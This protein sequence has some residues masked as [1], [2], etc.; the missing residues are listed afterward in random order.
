MTQ[1]YRIRRH[2]NARRVT[3]KVHP[4]QSLEV[5]APPRLSRRWIERF[6]HER[7]DWIEAAQTRVSQQQKLRP[8]ELDDPFPGRIELPAIGSSLNVRYDEQGIRTSLRWDDKDALLI[9]GPKT[10]D[11]V[12]AGLIH[13]LKSI[14]KNRL[15]PQLHA[16]A[17]QYGLSVSHVSWRN[18]KTRWGSCRR[19]AANV[20][21]ISLNIR[22]LLLPPASAR[23]VLVHEL[24]HI[25][26]PNH[27]AAFWQCVE[28]MQAD[29]REH[30]Q[31]IKRASLN[32]PC[33]IL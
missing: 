3:L 25:E 1:A 10:P 21:R 8:A 32:L 9:A 19:V 28:H 23:Y 16:L 4:D 29:Y 5:V 22:L 17:D 6:L 11:A 30:Q 14:A 27:S 20:G 24:A 31:A 7:A 33:W 12:K 2:P 15:E 13:A 26:H 18:Q